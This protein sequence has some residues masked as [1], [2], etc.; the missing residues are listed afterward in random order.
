MSEKKRLVVTVIVFG[1][2]LLLSSCR[3]RVVSTPDR[4]ATGVAEAKAVTAT[5]TSEVSTISGKTQV[6]TKTPY[7]KSPTATSTKTKT[8]TAKP[9]PSPKLT[10]TEPPSQARVPAGWKLFTGKG[11]EMYL[12]AGW[13]G[14]TDEVLDRIFEELKKMGG[15]IAS[16][17]RQFEAQRS[18]LRFFAFDF[19]ALRNN[20]SVGTSI[21]ATQ[22]CAS[23]SLNQALGIICQESEKA[24]KQAGGM[25]KCVQQKQTQVG[26]YKEAGYII[27]EE[28]L[29][30]QK[31]KAIQYVI[32]QGGC[33]WMVTLTTTPGDFGK[34]QTLLETAMETF[35]ITD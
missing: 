9:S 33:F 20:P 25:F 4:I 15:Q 21:N 8:P 23:I 10:A 28:E 16:L 19:E 2:L 22:A 30:G 17:A 34:Y 24:I 13:Q 1:L 32:K 12:P 7:L 3:S 18:E 14:G 35:R 27:A 5:L 6:P 29:G 26:H 31:M 11:L